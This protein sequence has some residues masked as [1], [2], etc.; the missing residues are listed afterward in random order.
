MTG[1]TEADWVARV[2]RAMDAVLADPAA[3]LDLHGVASQVHA[4]PYHFHRVFKQLTGETLHAFQKRVR[5]ERA[6]YRMA[7]GPS[8]RM[9]DLALEFGFGSASSFSRAFKEQYG[10]PPTAFDLQAW[11]DERRS[12][13]TGHAPQLERLP[14]GANPDGFEVELV[15]LP[16][17]TF[18]YLR[19]VDPYEPGRVTGAAEALVA[20]AE[21]RDLADGDWLGWM[22]EDPELVPLEQC[23]Y[24]VAVEVPAGTR[25]LAGP[26]AVQTLPACTAAQLAIRGPIELEQRALDWLYGTWLPRSGREPGHLPC[27]ERWHGRPFAHGFEHFELDLHLPLAD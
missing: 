27:M 26:V 15:A 13:L 20:W 23:R 7:H 10:V 4:S 12:E 24:D 22:W 6:L 16:E 8:V 14:A 9:L 1:A 2:N 17:R 19:V 5:L 11:R 21:E 3:A 18:A 25:V